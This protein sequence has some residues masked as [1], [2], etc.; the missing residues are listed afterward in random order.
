MALTLDQA[1]TNSTTDKKRS[2]G[3]GITLNKRISSKERKFFTEQLSLLIETGN[4]LPD[5][6]NIL[7]TQI[8]NPHF[9]IVVNDIIEQLNNGLSF[10]GALAQHP[11]VFSS[12][13]TTL[14]ASSEQGG[15][16]DKVLKHILD[17]EEKKE[18]LQN[19]LMSAFTYPVFLLVFAFAV[20]VFILVYVFPKFTEMFS[21]IQGSLPTITLVLMWLSDVTR[22]YWWLMIAFAIGMAALFL[23]LLSQDSGKRKINDALTRLPILGRLI[24]EIYLIQ[25]MRIIGLS[26]NNG[27][28]LTEAIKACKEIGNNS[29]FQAFIA[30]IQQNLTDGQK[31][32]RAFDT[33]FFIPSL[34]KQMV[35]TGEESGKLGLVCSKVADYYQRD[36]SKRLNTLAKIV[37]PV[38]LLVMGV[39]VGLVVSSLILPIFQLS[40]AVH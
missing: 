11:E 24:Y 15:Y 34:V 31:F 26:L 12:T 30:D 19:T 21:S 36:L 10:S 9:Q 4:T 28:T 13:Y 23:S 17:M 29:H 39:V 22:Q 8:E 33:T 7:S 3:S 20:V 2:A 14:I 25:S 5:S 6:L 32:S 40:R 38:M 1:Q 18:D 35:K 16:I 27:V 37:E